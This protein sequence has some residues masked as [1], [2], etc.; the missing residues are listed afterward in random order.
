MFDGLG[1]LDVAR[2]LSNPATTEPRTEASYRT[3]VGRAYYACYHELRRCLCDPREWAR[4]GTGGKKVYLSHRQ[5]RTLVR[6]RLPDGSVDLFDS[7]IELREH[8]D[9]HSW[10]PSS[11]RVGPPP[12]CLCSSWSPDPREN[13]ELAIRT[14]EELLDALD[15]VAERSTQAPGT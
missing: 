8:A 4:I 2:S 15:T 6:E 3:A 10:K 12:S 1:F 9:Y 5:L 13:S 7:L 14:A 11:A